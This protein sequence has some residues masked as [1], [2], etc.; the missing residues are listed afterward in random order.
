M[1]SSIKKAMVLALVAVTATHVFAEFLPIL[2]SSGKGGQG[3]A[4]RCQQAGKSY[5]GTYVSP[6]TNEKLWVNLSENRGTLHEDFCGC[7]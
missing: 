7:L 2:S 1:L 3:C 5:T 6:E 4:A